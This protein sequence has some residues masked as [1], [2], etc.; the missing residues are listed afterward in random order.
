MF[1]RP[2]MLSQGELSA[3]HIRSFKFDSQSD[4][5]WL[6]AGHGINCMDS[7]PRG[8]FVDQSGHSTNAM[9]G[10][11]PT[12]TPLSFYLCVAIN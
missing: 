12:A 3:L 10:M 6:S 7:S 8:G 1:D 2:V 11:D 5:N 4:L 9:D